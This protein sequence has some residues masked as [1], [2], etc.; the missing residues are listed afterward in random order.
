MI[1]IQR[2]LRIYK[3]E[4]FCEIVISFTIRYIIFAKIYCYTSIVRW[5]LMRCYLLVMLYY[6]TYFELLCMIVRARDAS[7]LWY[8]VTCCL[9]VVFKKKHWKCV[10][11]C[12]NEKKWFYYILTVSITL[13]RLCMHVPIKKP[14]IIYH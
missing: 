7:S 6:N 8:F 11:A 13:V 9:I 14:L 3:Y 5:C 1:G 2:Y 10:F 12:N 4:Y